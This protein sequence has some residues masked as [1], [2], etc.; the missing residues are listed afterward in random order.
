M[1]RKTLVEVDRE[2]QRL[3]RDGVNTCKTQFALQDSPDFIHGEQRVGVEEGIVWDVIAAH[4]EQPCEYNKYTKSL[5]VS[6]SSSSSSFHNHLI[7]LR[8]LCLIQHLLLKSTV[9]VGY[10]V[11]DMFASLS[12]ETD[13][14][15]V[16]KGQG[17]YSPTVSVI[18]N[19]ICFLFAMSRKSNQISEVTELQNYC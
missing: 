6:S 4:I 2:N 7:I 15:D 18:G 5:T 13:E 16:R 12:S 14:A 1:W 3:I 9:G 8:S 11:F 19:R 17:P 10:T